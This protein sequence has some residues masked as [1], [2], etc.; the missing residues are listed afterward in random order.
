MTTPGVSIRRL[1]IHHTGLYRALMLRAYSEHAT[2]YITSFE[3]RAG[4]PL[5]WWQ[6]RLADPT[7]VTLGAFDA[8]DALIGT[9]RLEL[10]Q[11]RRE[12]HKVELVSLYV[13]KDH[14]GRGIGRR[15]MD[16]ALVEARKWPGVE[17]MLLVVVGENLP[18]LRL[19]SRLGFVEYGRE[20]RAVKHA[21]RSYDKGLFWR[22]VSADYV[23]AA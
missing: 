16:D 10:Y 3:E 9:A 7:S 2:A 18:A 20:P 8:A 19:F 13:M 14:A 21:D 23:G 15:L 1:N 4:R 5:E 6:R 12:R 11:R 17:L 22:P